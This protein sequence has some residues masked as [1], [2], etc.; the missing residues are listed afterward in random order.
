MIRK[1]KQRVEERIV[2][3]ADDHIEA[4]V[5]DRSE[6]II[7]DR[8]SLLFPILVLQINHDDVV[9]KGYL[10]LIPNEMYQ[11]LSDDPDSLPDK[12]EHSTD[13]VLFKTESFPVNR[14]KVDEEILKDPNGVDI[15]IA[16]DFTEYDNIKHHNELGRDISI[17]V[18]LERVK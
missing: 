18:V 6:D 14:V 7:G 10:P 2:L 15:Y 3:L 12:I 16:N 4:G 8:V 9:Y 1:A 17:R 13:P 5:G 11:G